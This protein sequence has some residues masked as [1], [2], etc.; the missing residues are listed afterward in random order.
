MVILQHTGSLPLNRQVVVVLASSI[1][2]ASST[3]L[4]ALFRILSR[5]TTFLIGSFCIASFISFIVTV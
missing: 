5:P 4:I 2:K 1:I 3:A